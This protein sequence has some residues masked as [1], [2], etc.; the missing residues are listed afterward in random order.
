M[1]IYSAW[2][3][4]SIGLLKEGVVL[5]VFYYKKC[6]FAIISVNDVIKIQKGFIKAR[7]SSPKKLSL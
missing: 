5:K 3:V 6:Y 1:P 4:L 7:R 2:V